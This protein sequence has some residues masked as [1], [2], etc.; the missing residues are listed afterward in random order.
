ML[1]PP[2]SVRHL[3]QD[4][5]AYWCELCFGKEQTYS[6]AQRGLRLMEEAIE[7][8]QAA[9][10]DKAQLHAL[11]DYVYARPVGNLH[12]ELGGVGVTLLA[13]ANASGLYAEWCEDA[14]VARI[15]SMS[16]LKFANRNAEKNAA[17]FMAQS[18]TSDKD[19]AES[20]RNP[21]REEPTDPDG[22]RGA[23]DTPLG[24]SGYAVDN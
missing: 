19:L 7:A 12:Q 3:R 15:M 5:V 13:L 18:A 8:A 24:H 2:R 10:C 17:G 1:S 23:T 16:P 22:D 14:E 6:V 11:I 21:I 20:I 9:E 4:M